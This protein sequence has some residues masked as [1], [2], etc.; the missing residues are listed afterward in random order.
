MFAKISLPAI[1][2][3]FTPKVIAF[4]AVSCCAT[5][6]FANDLSD[7]LVSLPAQ[8]YGFVEQSISDHRFHYNR[9]TLGN[10]TLLIGAS[11]F[12]AN[13]GIDRQIQDRWQSH[14]HDKNADE[15]FSVFK[16]IGTLKEFNITMPFYAAAMVAGQ[17]P[18]KENSALSQ[19]GLWGSRTFRTILLGA[20]QQALLTTLLGGKRPRHKQAQWRML[21]GNRTVSGHAFYGAAPFINAS[22]MSHNDAVK[23]SWMII[24]TLPALAR[25]HENKH[26]FSQSLFGWGLAYLA[27]ASVHKTQIFTKNPYISISTVPMKGGGFIGIKFPF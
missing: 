18:C 17:L 14:L 12:I 22:Y 13:S 19:T 26:Y 16:K 2:K 24:S 20:P 8:S 9:Q 25:I 27:A 6:C 10:T 1:S 3:V 11:G 15:F 4:L 5:E 7:Y 23:T 21:S